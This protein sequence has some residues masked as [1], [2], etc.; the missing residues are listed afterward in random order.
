MLTFLTNVLTAVTMDQDLTIFIFKNAKPTNIVG[1]DLDTVTYYENHW[2]VVTPWNSASFARPTNVCYP[3]HK[4][5]G[6]KHELLRALFC[7]FWWRFH[8]L[9]SLGGYTKVERLLEPTSREIL[10]KILSCF[11]YEFK[12][13]WL[14][15]RLNYLQAFS[16]AVF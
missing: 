16:H 7:C 6:H 13:V 5:K 3:A 14:R 12:L 1:R 15:N 4:H 10:F 9:I 2:S 11:N 8:Y